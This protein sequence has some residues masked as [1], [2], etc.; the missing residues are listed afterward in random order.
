MPRSESEVRDKAKIKMAR[1]MHHLSQD[2][3]DA[4][5]EKYRSE[6]LEVVEQILLVP[7]LAI[8]D[9]NAELPK[10]QDILL[11]GYAEAQQDML[12]AGWLKEA[13]E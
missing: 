4:L 3:W 13:K 12:K 8:V 5:E 7:E 2:G 6:A 11:D 9:R 1:K 10:A